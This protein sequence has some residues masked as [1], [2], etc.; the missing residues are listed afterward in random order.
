MNS[1]YDKSK[2]Y[3]SIESAESQLVGTIGHTL[4]AGRQV[5]GAKRARATKVLLVCMVS[6]LVAA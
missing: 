4:H 3:A 5:Q 1:R 6:A 2:V